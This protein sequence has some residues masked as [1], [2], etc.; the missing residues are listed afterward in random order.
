MRIIAFVAALWAGL[1]AAL[2]EGGF[3]VDMAREDIQR[4]DGRQYVSDVAVGDTVE[5]SFLPACRQGDQMVIAQDTRLSEQPGFGVRHYVTRETEFT[6]S[7][8]A[9]TTDRTSAR[10]IR[11]ELSRFAFRDC[12]DVQEFR[13]IGPTYSVTKVNGATSFTELLKTPPFAGVVTN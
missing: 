9:E 1:S 2:A 12:E 5:V 7:I 6:V 13:E 10:D 3:V 4:L 11:N 8:K